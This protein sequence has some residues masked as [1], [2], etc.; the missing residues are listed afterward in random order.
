MHFI[1]TEQ[2]LLQ[3]CTEVK[4]VYVTNMPTEQIQL[5]IN[6]HKESKPKILLQSVEKQTYTAK[7]WTIYV[8]RHYFFC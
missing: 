5:N 6:E 3:L 8:R 4:S 2:I 1:E 7:F